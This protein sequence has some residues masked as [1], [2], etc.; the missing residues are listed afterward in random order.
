MSNA[1]DEHGEADGVGLE[2][3]GGYR[4][5]A[6]RSLL[7]GGA[8]FAIALVA[9]AGVSEAAVELAWSALA[10]GGLFVALAMSTLVVLFLLRRRL[11]EPR[12]ERREPGRPTR[13]VNA[14]FGSRVFDS[15]SW[16]GRAV[17]LTVIVLAAV[18]DPLFVAF[19]A[20]MPLG[21]AFITMPTIALMGFAIDRWRDRRRQ[22]SG[23][24]D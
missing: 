24:L 19:I 2:Y 7:V 11:A 15:D 4:R 1:S 5:L 14:I 10:F 8:G 13:L 12:K 22:R 23:G 3:P 21:L 18:Y 20:G 6:A 17:F 9:G 16:V